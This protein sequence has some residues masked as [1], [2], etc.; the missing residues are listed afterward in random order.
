MKLE[1]PLHVFENFSNIKFRENPSSGS[2][3][4]P[5]EQTDGRKDRRDEASSSFS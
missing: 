2:L 5:C 1:F 3:I 4:F